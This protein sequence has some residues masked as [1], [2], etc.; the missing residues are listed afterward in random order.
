M[1]FRLLGPLEV[2]REDETLALGGAKQRALLAILLL[3]A[4]RVVARERLA[5]LLWSEDPPPTAEH[6]IEVYVSQLRRVLEPD[7]AP[8]TV[9]VRKPS[10]YVLQVAPGDTDASQFEKLVE[11]ARSL[12]PAEASAQ[13]SRA[14]DMW[15]GPALA[16]FAGESFALGEAARLN[17]LHLHAREERIDAELALGRHDKLIGELQG[18]VEENPLRERLCGQLMLALYRAGRQAEASD[19]YQR[20]RERLVDELGMEPGPELQSLLKRILQQETGLAAAPPEAVGALPSGTMTFLLTDLEGSTR[21]W[22]RNPSAMRNAM[23]MHDEILGRAVHDHRGVQVESGREGDSILAVFVRASDALACAISIQQEMSRQEWPSGGDLH[24]RVAI[25]SGEAE[26]RGG[27]YYGPAVYRCARLLATA[28]GD[29]IVMTNAVHDLLVDDMPDGVSLRDLG[30]H[31]LRD[32]ERPERIFQVV[33][34]GLRSE[35]PPLKSM[36]PRRHNLPVS[37]TAFVGREPELA[38]IRERLA[39]SRMLT[40]IGAGGT[41]KTRLAL[42]AAAELSEGFEDGVWLVE[43]ASLTEAELVPQTVAET[44]GIWE[45]PGRSVLKTIVDRLSDRKVLLV[46]DNCEHLIPA[47]VGLADRLL[48]DCP[49]V[50][51]LATSRAALRVNGEAIMRVGPL[52]E[53]DAVVLFRDRAAAVQSGRSLSDSD[54]RAVEQICRRVEGIPLAIELAAGRARMMT[55]SE[56]LERLQKSF[57]VLAGGSRSADARHET[58][59]AA[60]DWSY[61]LLNQDEQQLF[62]RVSVFKGGFTLEAADEVCGDAKGTVLDLL[63]QLVDKSL[64]TPHEAM[65]GSTRYSILETVREYGQVRLVEA[66]EAELMNRR[67]AEHFLKFTRV[68]EEGLAGPQRR[69]WLQRLGADVDNLRAV[70]DSPNAPAASKLELASRLDGFWE[71][72]AEYNEGRARLESA[73]GASTERSGIRARA[74]V[75]AGLMTWAQGDQNTAARYCEEALEL[76]RD[77]GDEESTAAALQ[78]LGQIMIQLEKFGRA[79]ACLE[80]A[81]AIATRL[82]LGRIATLCEWRLGMAALFESDFGGAAVHIKASL[83]LAR[84]HGDVEM[85]AMSLWMLGNIALWEGSLDEARSHLTESLASLRGQGSSRS[86][87]NLLESLAAVAA[88]SRDRERALTL[89]GAAE[90]LRTRIEVVGSSRFHIEIR[91]RLDAVRRQKGGEAVWQAGARLSRDEAIDYALAQ[92][93]VPAGRAT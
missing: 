75:A 71:V 46:L 3:H 77:L 25:H 67:H 20:T 70:F 64:V 34:S 17:E 93:A 76:S 48:R 54:A 63:G 13:L 72:R 31:R 84:V 66:S 40:L 1:E 4:N 91:R 85:V 16:D 79:R 35:F 32:L 8:Y 19:V 22:D 83:E 21:R 27:H 23:A 74:L 14:L 90:A 2:R 58:L 49:D 42:Q 15:R 69:H 60:I 87:A 65:N 81:L 38:E 5:E 88:A 30:S 89:G 61:G 44:L 36:D 39:A 18:L 55:P 11:G 10:G 28:H 26:L 12:T 52:D 47:V 56:I 86:I 68:A 82:G 73:L 9:L 43:L 51:L 50:R 33:A 92:T 78:Q 80:E 24:L 59:K 57:A 7:G 37:T 53:S 45:E 41:G 62:R 29:Q 6:V